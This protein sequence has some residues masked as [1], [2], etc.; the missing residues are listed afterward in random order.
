MTCILKRVATEKM[1][2]LSAFSLACNIIQVVD[3][4][5]KALAMCKELYDRGTLSEYQDLEETTKHLIDLQRS[6]GLSGGNTPSSLGS[7]QTL[8]QQDVLLFEVAKQCSETAEQLAKKLRKFSVAGPHHKKR[9]SISK[10]FKA[11]WRGGD[12]KQLQRQLDAHQ[13]ALDTR[14]LIDLRYVILFFS[15]D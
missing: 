10:A 15:E 5:S 2:P 14:V 9:Q 3:F 13:K 6:L 4:G 7:A 12:I 11:I 8:P 1:D